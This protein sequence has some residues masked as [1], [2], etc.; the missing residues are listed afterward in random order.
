[1]HPLKISILGAGKVGSALAGALAGRPKFAVEVIDCS[2]DAIDRLRALN[3][4]V[5]AR[6]YGHRD[7]LPS[8][9][10]GRDVTVAAVPEAAAIEIAAAAVQAG[11]HYLDFSPARPRTREVLAP[12]A[13]H[14][15]VMTGCGVSP[16]FIDNVAGDLLETVSSVSDL[17]IRVGAIPRFPTNR[18]GYGQI[19]NVDSLIDEYTL[20]SAAVRDGRSVSLAPLEE[21]EQIRIDG[22][23]YEGFVTSGGLETLA[24]LADAGPRNITFKTLRYPGHLD[25]MRFLLDDLGLRHRRDMLRS[26]LMNGLPQIDDDLLLLAVTAKGSR[27][28]RPSEKTLVY[29]FRPLGENNPFN[30]LNSVAAG[31]AAS[32]LSMLQ[33]GAIAQSGFIAHH[34]FRASELLSGEFLNPLLKN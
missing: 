9:L 32:L 28:H 7:E 15:A 27:E 17:T 22:V 26:L 30:A 13:E 11:S 16:G 23:A 10:A 12:L 34:R 21:Y 5:A 18:L 4:P 24:T 25:Y 1:M 19:W 14:R 29:S 3:L 31:Y 20:P 33:S 2:E 8:L 6:S